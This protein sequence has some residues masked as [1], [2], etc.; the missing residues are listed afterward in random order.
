MEN[1]IKN[2]IQDALLLEQLYRKDKTSFINSFYAV[3]E[4]IKTFPAAQNWHARLNYKEES[5]SLKWT[6][7][8]KLILLI[9]ILSGL[10]AKL[11]SFI[12]MEFD[13]YYSRNISFIIFPMLSVYFAWKQKCSLQTYLI[14]T[15]VFAIS[16]LYI[17]FL[18]YNDKSNSILLATIHLPIF[19][20]MLLGYAFTGG[21]VKDLM[22]PVAYLKFNGNFIVMTGLILIASAMFTGITIAL[23]ELLK[24]DITNFYFEQIAVWGFAVIPMMSTYLVQNNP[25]LV[26][27][28]SPIIAKI[29]TPLVS[30][31]LFTFLCTLVYTGKNVYNDR[32]FLL[33]F[34]MLLIVVMAI[35]LFSVT[36]I[37]SQQKSIIQVVM[38]ISLSFLTIIANAIALS[39]IGFRLIELGITPNR[40][41]VLGTNLLMFIHL[42]FV[43]AALLKNIKGKNTAIDIEKEIAKFLPFYAVWVAFV[44][45]V[46]PFIFN[47]K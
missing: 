12:G 7:E 31:T 36:T 30:I 35:I 38:L 37:N 22:K 5:F 2:N 43:A 17:N 45:F 44:T 39:A 26:N 33:L 34:N 4:E 46:M 29:F 32:N 41:A 18:P 16:A 47:L 10:I 1:K 6:S 40:L 11:P 27:K 42:F 15:F 19:L 21:D 23:F 9:T 14:P 8:I 20:W 3:Y 13:V 24:I 28:I 25:Q